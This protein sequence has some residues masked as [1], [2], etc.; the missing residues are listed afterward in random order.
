VATQNPVEY[1]GTYPLPEAQLDRFQLKVL[2]PVPERDDELAVLTRHAEGFDP[3]DL[4]TC[5]I[6]AVAGADD[7]AAARAA[8]QR[9]TLSPE[10]LGYLLDVCRATRTVS[11]VE[12]GASPRAATALLAATRAAAWLAGRDYVTPDDVKALA[13]PA[14][15]HRLRL[16]PEAELDGLTTDSVLD[17][18]L[19]TVPV[20]R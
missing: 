18:A 9:V 15:R 3:R 10:V 19:N 20:P 6:T 13:R 7:L 2:M 12:V 8:V 5:G 14:L 1:E 17:G 16:R 11:A 4:D